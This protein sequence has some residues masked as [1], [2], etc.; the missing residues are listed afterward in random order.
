MAL[1]GT[2]IP[3]DAQ[4]GHT[5]RNRFINGDMRLWQR[6]TTFSSIG[7]STYSADRWVSNYG[8]TAPTF[9]RS[10]DAPTGFQYSFS[11]AGSSTSYHGIL[12]RIESIN[13]ADLSGQVVTLS[14]YAKLSSGTATGGLS[15]SFSSANSVDNFGATTNI[16]ETNI[17]PTV[18]GS[19]TR[20]SYTFTVT[21]TAA[22][23][24]FHVVVFNPSAT[25]TSTL[26]LTG[27]QLERGSV[28]TP[29]EFRHIGTELLLC[30][31][32]YETT[33]YPNSTTNHDITTT[34][35]GVVLPG[36]G[37]TTGFK[38]LV[39]KRA[40]PTVTLYS[41]NNTAGRVSRV[42]DGVDVSGGTAAVSNHGST[43]VWGVILPS[44]QTVGAG[45]EIAWNA[46]AEL[47]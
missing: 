33:S 10:T 43:G 3:S 30:Q 34:I 36:G 19:W 12:Q 38:Y 39:A 40:V 28:A 14:F 24:G 46:S 18:S 2:I 42:S 16:L 21:S 25:Q 7:T 8:G 15:L 1:F 13:T 27:M 37:A 32:Y 26:L 44:T 23:N 22:A 9:S 6:G 45:I 41:R 17:T 35:I 20:Y 29:F 11:L 4:G 31:R 47:T 5:F